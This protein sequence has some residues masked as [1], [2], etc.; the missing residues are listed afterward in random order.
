M[1]QKNKNLEG[2]ILVIEEKKKNLRA[3]QEVIGDRGIYI[4]KAGEALD[5]MDKCDGVI[6][7][8]F[9]EGEDEK[10]KSLYSSYISYI[11]N[12]GNDRKWYNSIQKFQQPYLYSLFSMPSYHDDLKEPLKRTLEHLKL[13][14]IKKENLEKHIKEFDPYFES[15]IEYIKK[16]KRLLKNLP[17]IKPK[18]AYGGPIMIEAKKRGK[19]SVLVTS[20]SRFEPKKLYKSFT[21]SVKLEIV[22]FP[23]IEEAI[24]EIKDGS[25]DRY[26]KAYDGWGYIS[27]ANSK[28]W[29]EKDQRNV[30]RMA[31]D[32]LDLKIECGDDNYNIRGIF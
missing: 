7:N 8:L 21:T 19:P 5:I 15:E 29:L 25:L 27:D 13:C 30:W 24:I 22:L 1:K 11:K 32:K 9:F 18:F 3:C 6:T 31:L 12:L 2:K 28:C 26:R 10:M 20:A 14:K 4:Q 16:L 23:L 17:K